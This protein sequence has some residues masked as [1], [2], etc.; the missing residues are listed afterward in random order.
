MFLR[1]HK[2]FHHLVEAYA[3]QTIMLPTYIQA[4]KL[5]EQSAEFCV[6]GKSVKLPNGTRIFTSTSSGRKTEHTN[7]QEGT[8]TLYYIMIHSYIK[9]ESIKFPEESTVLS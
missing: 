2:A 5:G 9:W 8:L 1:H 7:E 4:D 6:H 3:N